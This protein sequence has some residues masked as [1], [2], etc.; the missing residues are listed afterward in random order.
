M[1]LSQKIPKNDPSSLSYF[2]GCGGKGKAIAVDVFAE[3]VNWFIAQAKIKGVTIDYIIDT[4]IHADHISGGYELSQKAGGKYC[5]HESSQAKFAFKA[6]SDGQNLTIGNVKVKIIHTPGHTFDS[7]CLLVS[8]NRR[9]SKPWFLLSGHTLFVGSV[10]RPDLAGHEAEMAEDLYN[11]IHKKILTLPEYIEIYPGAQA[12][13]VCGAGLSGKPT[14][15]IYFEK[16]FNK[17]LSNGKQEFIKN[18]L[19]N[20]PKKPVD[21]DKIIEKNKVV[22]MIS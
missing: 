9:T 19:S 17:L 5:L 20:L 12:G 2:F 16:Y 22:A 10:G 3:D 15:T 8:D 18:I 1:F 4:H 7:I 21:V 11:S 14:S 13:S 6:L